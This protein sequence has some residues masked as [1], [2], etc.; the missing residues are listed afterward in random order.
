MHRMRNASAGS[1]VLRLGVLAAIASSLLATG[2]AR[3][4]PSNGFPSFK[5]TPTGLLDSGFAWQKREY[6]VRCTQGAAAVSV[7]GAKGW[8][9]KVGKGAYRPGAFT[10][11]VRSGDGRRT[12]V[13][14]RK[15]GEGTRMHR[16]HLRCLP[17]DF[18]EYEFQR[19]GPGGPPFFTIQMEN[20]YAVIVDG[21]GVPVWWYQADRLDPYNV[22]LQPDGTISFTQFDDVTFEES[23]YEVRSL[24][25][26][27]LRV[28][29][30]DG[31]EPPDLHELVLLDN[32]NYLLGMKYPYTDDTSA[33]D[34]SVNSQVLGIQI[35][36]VTPEGRIVYRWAS[37]EH[38]SASE[39]G[40]RWWDD[41]LLDREPYDT[42]HWNSVELVGKNRMLL[43]FRHLDAILMVNRTTGAI[44]WK[45]G[46]TPTPQS[47]DVIGDPREGPTLFGGQHDARIHPNGTISIY[48]NRS[49][50]GEPPRVARYRI[51]EDARTATLVQ[52]FTDPE[53]MES[54]CCGSARR[55]PHGEWLVSWGGVF[56]TGTVGA[57]ERT[58]APIFRLTVGPSFTYRAYPVAEDEIDVTELRQAMDKLARRARA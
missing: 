50:L 30:A 47:L 18:P 53:V 16:F 58:G 12:V 17:A 9:A 13:T 29:Q 32:G 43:S 26:R 41:Q 14:F 56:G 19:L 48:D 3:A 39:T 31:T 51:D 46:G 1:M 11:P 21:D 27:L 5:V 25:G 7:R 38:I 37:G 22:D 2:S 15:A 49:A 34:G 45:L 4:A 42:S 33:F 52:Q 36:E 20:R 28:V 57:Y 44:I 54:F 8:R 24:T 10:A 23:D 40:L 35:L 55:L 6:V